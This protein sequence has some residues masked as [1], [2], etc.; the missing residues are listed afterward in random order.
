MS[1]NTIKQNF[2]NQ[3]QNSITQI[4]SENVLSVDTADYNAIVNSNAG[5]SRDV[6]NISSTYG[7]YVNTE[8]CTVLRNNLFAYHDSNEAKNGVSA[9]LFLMKTDGDQILNSLRAPASSVVLN[10]IAV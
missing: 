4:S 5:N 10:L 9:V 2:T 8:K 3:I 7:S 6:I 1:I